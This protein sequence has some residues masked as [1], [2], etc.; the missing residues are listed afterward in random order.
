M[1]QPLVSIITPC[2][3]GEAFLDRYFAS[4]LTQTYSNLE[5]IFVNDGST[6]RT[7]EI[8]LSYRKALEQKGIRYI[9]EYQE[10][11]GQ[12]AAL[13][14]GLKLF[15]G[16]Y[17]TW[18]DSD[19]VM[20]P[21]CIEKKVEFLQANPQFGLCICRTRVVN[22]ADPQHIL[23]IYERKKPE[24]ED[25]FYEDLIYIRN[26]YFV[27]GG[28]MVR[29]SSL[30]R[31]IPDRDIYAGR[32]GQNLQI[33]LPVLKYDTCGYMLDELNTYYVR[34]DSHSHSADDYKNKIHQ[35]ALYT[36]IVLET[37]ARISPEEEKKYEMKVK[38]HY[39]RWIYGN[40]VDAHDRRTMKKAFQEMRMTGNVSL[41][42][43]FVYYYKR[44]ISYDGETA[45]I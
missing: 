12:A 20:T 13:N 23:H 3:N 38:H 19:D 16:D 39:A 26:V 31:A 40:A 42:E 43:R 10:N 34:A 1:S 41:K 29:S 8:A 15:S 33:L 36:T 22:E 30:L 4:V 24:Q 11:A 44:L 5:L 18:P 6:D 28:Y 9:Y 7:E 14:R 37:L 27:P 45:G 17:L 2:Y 25:N 21:D 32:G 35:I